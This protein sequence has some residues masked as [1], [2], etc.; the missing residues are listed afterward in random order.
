MMWLRF[1]NTMT[2]KSILVIDK[3]KKA[4]QIEMLSLQK[5]NHLSET[6]NTVESFQ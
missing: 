4:S 2:T 3:G 5:K 1:D 6:I